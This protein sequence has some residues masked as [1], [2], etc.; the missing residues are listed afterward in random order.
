MIAVLYLTLLLKV[1]NLLC[2]LV[3]NLHT[4]LN[5]M[6]FG[7]PCQLNLTQC[8]KYYFFAWCHDMAL[9]ILHDVKVKI[10]TMQHM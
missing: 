1:N 8:T 7:A 6:V 3:C 4:S 10:D 9:A 2:K 5:D